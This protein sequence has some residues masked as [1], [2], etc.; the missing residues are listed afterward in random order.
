MFTLVYLTEFFF[1]YFCHSTS[2]EIAVFTVDGNVESHL[3]CRVI[4]RPYDI[5]GTWFS[6]QYLISG[7][8]H[9]LA[10]M[11]STSIL[12]LNKAN[13]KVDSEHVPIMNQ[14]YKFYN[15]N[16]SSVRAI[17]MAK[18]PWLD[19][20]NDPLITASTSDEILES[21]S[22][23]IEMSEH[24]LTVQNSV[25]NPLSHSVSLRR[26]FHISFDESTASLSLNWS[27]QRSNDSTIHYLD[28]YRREFTGDSV[29]DESVDEEEDE[30][31]DASDE[32]DEMEN[33]IPKYLIFSTGSKTYI[34]SEGSGP[35]EDI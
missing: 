23:D 21:P 24:S 28:E 33:S 34:P 10:Q 25:G 9:W 13:Q 1:C 7:D 11:V 22:D 8:L 31:M 29:S 15:R 6:D 26:A 5:F 18:C 30:P 19:E 14:L 12:W 32:Y 4:N 2:G 27:L 35:V 20:S 16:A 17:M 3:R